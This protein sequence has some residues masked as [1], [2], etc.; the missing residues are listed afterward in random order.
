MGSVNFGVDPQQTLELAQRFGLRV[1][2]ETGLYKGKTAEWATRHF[3][4]VY[5]IEKDASRLIK[6]S[7]GM[8]AGG[9]ANLKLI[10]GDSRTELAALLATIDEPCLLWLDAHWCGGSA[11]AAHRLDD[12]CPLREELAAIN[13]SEYAAHHVIMIDD[14]RLFLE[15]PPY[16]HNPA[17]WPTFDEVKTLLA[18]R[19]V[20]IE[21]DVIYAEPISCRSSREHRMACSTHDPS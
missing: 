9:I 6:T 2:V 19:E 3:R 11:E 8:D 12:E 1:F 17:Q 16:P 7:L 14:A 21:N 10:N 13:A 15:P 18:P 5:S 4:Q 20:Y